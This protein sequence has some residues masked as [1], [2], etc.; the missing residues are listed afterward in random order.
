M[1]EHGP[2]GAACCPRPLS[3]VVLTAAHPSPCVRVNFMAEIV[4]TEKA[5]QAK[6]V[7]A[8]VGTRYG[9]ILP[10]EGHL[11]MTRLHGCCQSRRPH[12]RTRSRHGV[13]DGPKECV[14]RKSTGSAA[15]RHE[16]AGPA[17]AQQ[18]RE[19]GAVDSMAG[20]RRA[21]SP[22]P[23]APEHCGISEVFG[24]STRRS[25]NSECGYQRHHQRPRAKN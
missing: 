16:L 24:L 7:R 20:Y 2:E 12:A 17:G 14:A 15:L 1:R 23:A 22:M 10:A 6:D 25:K 3:V 21:R 5:S 13:L 11:W 9:E 19:S 8:A 4:I 18:C